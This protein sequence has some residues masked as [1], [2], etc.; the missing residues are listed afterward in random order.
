M[1]CSSK[2]YKVAEFFVA[3]HLHLQR[4]VINKLERNQGRSKS[5]NYEIVTDKARST[6][7]KPMGLWIRSDVGQFTSE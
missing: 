6:S 3:L 2:I 5:W 1:Y 7:A 4:T